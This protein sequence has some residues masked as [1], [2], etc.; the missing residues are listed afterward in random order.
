[1][2]NN[3]INKLI[4]EKIFGLKPKLEYEVMRV[5]GKQGWCV[6]FVADDLKHAQEWANTRNGQFKYEAFEVCSNYSG[7]ITNAFKVVEEMR[8]KEFT[9]AATVDSL[10]QH[11]FAFHG[12]WNNSVVT[13]KSLPLAICLAALSALGENK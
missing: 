5:D 9:W 7:D 3:E 8:K 12:V 6:P 11:T 2:E 1:M 10:G 4:H 13:D